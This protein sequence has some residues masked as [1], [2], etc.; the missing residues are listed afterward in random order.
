MSSFEPAWVAEQL[1][2]I[3][4]RMI[5]TAEQTGR[6]ELASRLAEAAA[7]LADT[8]ARVTVVGQFKQ[9]KSALVNALVAAPVCP[10]DDVLATA[11][12][13][14]VRW[15]EKVT[16]T[17]VTELGGEQR[18]IHTTIDPSE[19]RSHVTEL[20]GDSGIFGSLRAEVTVPRQLL[21]GDLVL[22]DTPGVGRAQA[23]PATNL[24]LLPQTDAVV[25]V[26]DATQELTAPE[27]DFLRQA[28]VLCPRI[29]C[30]V[31]KSDLQHNWRSIVAANTEHLAAAGLAAPIIVTS[32]LLHDLAELHDDPLL[33]DEARIDSL[34]AHLRGVQAEIVRERQRLVADEIC[35]VGRH[36]SMVLNAELEVL[37]NPSVGAETVQDLKAAETAAEQLSLQSAR[38]QQTLGDGTAELID[39]IEFDLRD[40]LRAVGR[41]AEALIDS[42]DPGEAWDEIG[43][44]LAD[45][46]TAAVSENFIWAFDRSKHLAEV[47]SKH[48]ALDG[49]AAV[50]DLTPPTVDRALGAVGSIDFVR[51]GSLSIGQKVM[52]GL[53]GSYGGVLMF[54]LMTTFAG[55]ALVNPVSI[56]AGLIMGGFAYRQDANQRLEQRR[57]E[58]K[59]A[60]RKLIDEAIFQVSKDSRDRLSGVKRVLRDHFT[61]VADDFKRS[62]SDSIRSAKRS[63]ALPPTEQGIRAAQVR[64]ELDLLQKLAR[65]SQSLTAPVAA[66]EDL[67]LEDRVP[68]RST[69]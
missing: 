56:A 53:K 36:L 62:L 5:Q 18:P 21:S 3:A 43:V 37:G 22:V 31:S 14:V 13:T 42:S 38:W 15:G 28:S 52:I 23:R 63:A 57:A 4:Q 59:N 35:S 7:T 30:V 48:F 46:V 49:R 58:A 68:E 45:S 32:A 12:P 8:S 20:A 39:D 47:V 54:G 40:R 1:G 61:T 44:W 19:L 16:A 24:A 10:V 64:R 50:P 41:E 2:A 25:M 66:V 69:A 6:D 65:K 27:L 9:G 67:Q 26:T 29:A 34:R 55:M 60:V 11:V 17:L 33:R 51:S